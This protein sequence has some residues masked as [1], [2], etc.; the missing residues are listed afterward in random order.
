[1]IDILSWLQFVQ[2]QHIRQL[3]LHEQVKKYNYYL[4]EQHLLQIQTMAQQAVGGRRKIPDTGLTWDFVIA[5]DSESPVYYFDVITKVNKPVTIIAAWDGTDTISAGSYT[6]T[7]SPATTDVFLIELGIS[8]TAVPIQ[9]TFSDP[10]AID[11]LLFPAAYAI[12]K[13]PTNISG[14]IGTQLIDFQFQALSDPAAL[15]ISGFT[16]NTFNWDD[17]TSIQ[18]VNLTNV[19]VTDYLQFYGCASLSSLTL[20]GFVFNENVNI[21]FNGCALNESTVNQLLIL[22]D[23][24][25][26]GYAD[27]DISN[28]GGFGN[29]PPTGDGETARLS[30]V[31]KGWNI[32]YNPVV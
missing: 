13:A 27:I 24:S 1:M 20:T 14:L 21:T 8:A 6:K 31:S 30:L 9:I 28:E 29:A 5:T 3:P 18:S 16:G 15:D 11:S 23:A 26:V 10:T 32:S 17:D 4:M 22:A 19:N 7:I 2:L 25:G 12:V